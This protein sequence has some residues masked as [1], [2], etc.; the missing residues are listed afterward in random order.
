MS[1]NRYLKGGKNPCC[2]SGGNKVFN[3]Q[4]PN[5]QTKNKQTNKNRPLR[6]R[7]Q[8]KLLVAA[9]IPTRTYRHK[10]ASFAPELRLRTEPLTIPQRIKGNLLVEAGHSPLN[11][12]DVCSAFGEGALGFPSGPLLSYHINRAGAQMAEQDTQRRITAP[13]SPGSGRS[14]T[15]SAVALARLLHYECNH[16]L[17]LYVSYMFTGC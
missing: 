6:R 5:K 9:R 13:D 8:L 3:L 12:R 15:A 16:L 1:I 2:H 17:Q 14:R 7:N 10:H 4:T 11:R